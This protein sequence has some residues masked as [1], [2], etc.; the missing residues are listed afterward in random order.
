[1]YGQIRATLLNNRVLYA[2][3]KK[4]IVAARATL[5]DTP[6]RRAERLRLERED[7]AGVGRGAAGF[8]ESDDEGEAPVVTDTAA[9]SGGAVGAN[10]TL[11]SEE[12]TR[13]ARYQAAQLETRMFVCECL[14]RV[15]CILL[16]QFPLRVEARYQEII[17]FCLLEATFGKF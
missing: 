1:M 12:E 8:A 17:S 16:D 13:E 14:N 3:S 7:G 10:D 6:K 4:S 5:E 11:L 2:T 9:R 15:I